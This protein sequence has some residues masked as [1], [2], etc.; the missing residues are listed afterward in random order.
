[1]VKLKTDLRYI[2]RYVPRIYQSLKFNKIKSLCLKR[3]KPKWHGKGGH[4]DSWDPL[5]IQS[6]PQITQKPVGVIPK[7]QA[8]LAVAPVAPVAQGSIL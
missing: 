6:P 2:S 3:S 4:K 7:P 1:V 8:A 5:L